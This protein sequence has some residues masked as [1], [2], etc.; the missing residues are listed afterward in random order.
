MQILCGELR[1]NI[2]KNSCRSHHFPAAFRMS[3]STP[4][5]ML[6]T[7]SVNY[8][9]MNQSHLFQKK[10]HFSPCPP[11]WDPRRNIT[12]SGSPA[13]ASSSPFLPACLPKICINRGK[14]SLDKQEMQCVIYNSSERK[15]TSTSAWTF[16]FTA[17]CWPR[18]RLREVHGGGRQAGGGV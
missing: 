8:I 15:S 18:V 2:K 16:R 6:N 12:R 17:A 13:I 5:N 10:I 1:K 4:L 9:D 3:V 11:S 14:E 7:P